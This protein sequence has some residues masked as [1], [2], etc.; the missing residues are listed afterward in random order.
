[1]LLDGKAVIKILFGKYL[2]FGDPVSSVGI[3]TLKICLEAH[4]SRRTVSVHS[5]VGILL[6]FN[7]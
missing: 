2:V 6:A 7:S 4:L 5:T 3:G 1:M